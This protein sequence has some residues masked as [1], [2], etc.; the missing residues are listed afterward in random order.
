M[1]HTTTKKCATLTK[2]ALIEALGR[3]FGGLQWTSHYEFPSGPHKGCTLDE[4]PGTYLKDVYFNKRDDPSEQF[5][6]SVSLWAQEARFESGQLAGFLL[7][8][9][10]SK[11]LKE[12]KASKMIKEPKN[13][14]L[15]VALQEHITQ[16]IAQKKA[17]KPADYT[18]TFGDY[19]GRNLRDVPL[20]YI[21][22]LKKDGTWKMRSDLAGALEVYDQEKRAELLASPAARYRFAFSKKH[23]GKLITEIPN[24][25]V[26]R[27]FA[28][29]VHK[30]CSRRELKDALQL[31]D[32]LACLGKENWERQ[33]YFKEKMEYG[34]G[35]EIEYRTRR[36]RK[37]AYRR[38]M[39]WQMMFCEA[40]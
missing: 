1:S 5:F 18:L 40:Y 16:R 21:N 9:A 8:S 30:K 35:G 23:G 20:S 38:N 33:P 19:K 27:L 11:Y 29:N 14:A 17:D 26:E 37:S 32:Q 24:V 36:E 31:W 13:A 12:V 22:I 6:V 34:N 10:S 4:V 39:S 25:F 3:S 2:D 7:K 15:A 28:K